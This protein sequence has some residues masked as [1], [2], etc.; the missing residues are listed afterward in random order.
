MYIT[1]YHSL[2][3]LEKFIVP[4]EHYNYMYMALNSEKS[5]NKHIR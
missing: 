5:K 4:R 2:F 1:M 3:Q